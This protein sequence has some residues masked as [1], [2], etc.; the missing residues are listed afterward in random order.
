[1]S[2]LRLY[3]SNRLEILIDELAHLLEAPLHSPMSPEVIVTQSLGMKRWVSFEL[4]HRFGVLTNCYFP[5]PNIIIQEIL[6]AV[7]DDIPEER[8][9]DTDI[10]TWRI[11]KLL[12]LCVEQV[13]FENIRNYLSQDDRFLKSFQL[14][15]QIANIFDQYLTFRPDMIMS[16]ERGEGEDWQA[17]L[18]RMLIQTLANGHPPAL[19]E[20]FFEKIKDPSIVS[21]TDLP[22]RISIFGISTLPIFH[23][24]IVTAISRFIDVNIFL[25][26]PTQ[27]YWADIRSGHDIA[28]TLRQEKNESYTVDELHLEKGNSLLASMGRI[29]KDFLKVIMKFDPQ[30]YT[31]FDDPGYDSLLHSIQSDI[32][33]MIDRGI[34]T[35]EDVKKILISSEMIQE[36]RSIRINSCHSPMREVEILYDFLLDLFNS[37]PKLEPRDV[38]VMTPDIE[39]YS[40]FIQAMFGALS[41]DER[42]IPFSIADRSIRRESRIVETFFSI[43]DLFDSRFEASNVLKIVECEDI[44]RRFGLV[45]DDLNLI[46][47]WV[48]ETRICW[49]I[50]GKYRSDLG[51]PEFKENTWKTGIERLLLGYAMPLEEGMMFNGI[52]PYNNIEGR[53]SLVLGRFL[54]F[55]NKLSAYSLSF[56]TRKT[57]SK[58][59]RSLMTLID[60]FF[61]SDEDT[62]S[63]VQTLRNAVSRLS[64]MEEQSDFCELI[65]LS[66][67]KS[68]LED[69]ISEESLYG[70]FLTGRVTFCAMLPMRSIPFKVICMI[71]MNDN[72]FPRTTKRVSFDLTAKD[73]KPGDRSIRDDDRYIFL[74]SIISARDK[75]Y[76]S[77]VGQGILDNSE[78]PSSV[79]VSELL[80]Y[81]N[82]GYELEENDRNII[83]YIFTRHP[84]Q[85]FSMQ[86]FN[87]S[88]GLFSYSEENYSACL[89][90]MHDKKK[91]KPFITDKLSD[92]AEDINLIELNDLISFFC[93]PA[94]HLLNRRLGIYIN[95]SIDIIED[96]EPFALDNLE[97]YHIEQRLLDHLL[98]DKDKESLYKILR[99]EGALPIGRTGDIEFM[100][101]VHGASTFAKNIK[102]YMNG[103]N[104]EPYDIDI[105]F[106]DFKLIGKISNLWPNGLIHYRYAK[107]KAKYRLEV[108]ILHLVL[109]AS[110]QKSFSGKSYL[111]C[112]DNSW[113]IAPVE[114]SMNLLKQLIIIYK[115]GLN[116]LLHFFPET[117]LEF[118]INLL[119]NRSREASLER[120]LIKWEGGYKQSGEG[121]DLYYDQ[122]F[123]GVNLFNDSFCRLSIDIYGPLVD[124][125][126]VLKL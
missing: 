49:G 67:V 93:N 126:K 101:L 123:R 82:Q 125:Q 10:I 112:K 73:P 109:N 63:D 37:D 89:S 70:G 45:S 9:L 97:K 55:F 25:M 105:N 29:G 86:Y 114:D 94:R 4:A 88:N 72:D 76:I 87:G 80:D 26:S 95:Q 24:E 68:F 48:S 106:S 91:V 124:N 98:A 15:S 78:L 20:Q 58:W 18:W 57:L 3:T 56:S 92:N 34:P 50:E 23:M 117:S 52:L 28:K 22:E 44:Q 116:E 115:R 30:D 21:R 79:L 119:N 6:H 102:Y 74:E 81:I 27:M 121:E 84:L 12:P 5:F 64:V 41:D 33:N 43:L 1:M 61:S 122:C 2:E 60:D 35:D 59:D 83:D 11:M 42:K 111:F 110:N 38:I 8:Y 85:A 31:C 39:K 96:R 47:R 107:A 51:L 62:E 13:G 16:W 90:M 53:E 19:R 66:L 32:L 75:L 100:N 77:Y 14:S 36:D 46:R 104:Q 69:S 103:E 7:I 118:V 99:A 65:D 17:K 71:G 113:E 108:W 40:P 120:A 54:E